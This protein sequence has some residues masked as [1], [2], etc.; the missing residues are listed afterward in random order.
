[1]PAAPSGAGAINVFQ[2]DSADRKTSQSSVQL[3]ENMALSHVHQEN[4]R[5][6]RKNN[7]LL[8][9]YVKIKQLFSKNVSKKKQLLSKMCVFFRFGFGNGVPS[10]SQHSKY[11]PPWSNGDV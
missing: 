11:P 2:N 9:K 6:N 10:H 3:E 5:E 7:D 4:Q 8:L 1:M